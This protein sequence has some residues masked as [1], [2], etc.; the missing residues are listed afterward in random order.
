MSPKPTVL[1]ILD[2]FG[3]STQTNY[4]AIAHAKKPF[5]DYVYKHYPHTTLAASGIAVGLLP[6]MM[7][8]S[9][10]GHLTIGCAR[11]VKQDATRIQESIKNGSFFSMN[12][13]VDNLKKIAKNG[14]PLHCIGLLSDGGVHSHENS[15]FALLQAAKEQNIKQVIVHAFLDGRDVLPQS[16]SI[17]LKR[18][19]AAMNTIG[20]GIIGSLHGRFYAMDRD[21]NWQ[22]TQQA[23]QVLTQKQELQFDSWTDAIQYYYAQNITDE[24]IPPTQLNKNAIIQHDDGVIF[25]NHR[26]DRA[27]QLTQ[28]FIDPDCNFF[29][30]KPLDLSFFMTFVSYDNAKLPCEVLFPRTVIDQTLKDVLCAH[31]K[32]IFTIAE[33]EKYAHVTY[34]FNGGREEAVPCETRVL[35][36]S[37]SAQ[38]YIKKPNMSAD[39]ITQTVLESL[40][41]DPK[42]F[43]LMNYANADMV[44]HSGNFRAT[45]QAVE[46]LDEQLKKLYEMVVEKMN[47]TLIITADHGNAEE[48]IDL[49]TGQPKTSHTTNKVPFISIN[50]ELKDKNIA[51]T[52]QE[53]RDIAPYIL[54]I[55][56]ISIPN[57]WK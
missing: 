49:A 9:E 3:I 16:A 53:L 2:G 55:M 40:R 38:N 20:I 18:L 57:E 23:Y 42:D 56:N 5:L 54:T 10:V 46:C 11:I 34:F 28:A 32:T 26:P 45:V 29:S 41:H 27:R 36:P 30:H 8:N 14:H 15:L 17:Y 4:N 24:F 43:Y 21:H 50:K 25:F 33:T 52:L 51:L 19:E 1:A 35:I 44:G 6:N 48:M 37:I 31:G 47:G 7:G 12:I 39:K 13:L 22:R